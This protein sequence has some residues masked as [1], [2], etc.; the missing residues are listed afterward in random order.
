S[1]ST[2]LA[3]TNNPE[4]NGILAQRAVE[5]FRPDTVAT[6]SQSAL[7]GSDRPSLAATGIQLAFAPQVS[8]N[9][10]SQALTQNDVQLV[11]VVLQTENFEAQQAELQGCIAAG[12]L[13]PLLIERGEHLQIM[14]V[15]EFW[16][17]GDRITC[18]LNKASR[19][20]TPTLSQS[21]STILPLPEHMPL[22]PALPQAS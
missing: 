9:R 16:L 12:H 20:K 4:L 5:L 17:M 10:W 19:S 6:V 18:L 8:L 3:L 11:E 13:L 21:H 7:N 2:F 22:E 1:L 14:L 15:D